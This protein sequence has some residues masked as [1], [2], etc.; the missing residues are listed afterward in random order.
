MAIIEGIMKKSVFYFFALVLV[1]LILFSCG[2]QPMFIKP[3][4]DTPL[5][6]VQNGNALLNCGKIDA[7]LKEYER[8]KDLDPEFVPAF[9]GLALV[10]GHKGLK[11]KS[12]ETMKRAEALVKS[13]EEKTDVKKGYERLEAILGN[14]TP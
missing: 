12:H 9:V 6:H 2:P 13:P 1:F 8:A 3:G 7:A 5:H 4:I 10:F 11:E 14:K